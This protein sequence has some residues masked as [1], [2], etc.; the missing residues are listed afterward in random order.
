MAAMATAM[1]AAL[2]V[3][4]C[5]ITPSQIGALADASGVAA[6]IGWMVEYNP[7]STQKAEVSQVVGVISV[8]IGIVGTNSYVDVIFPK[9]QAYVAASTNLPAIDKPIILGGAQAVLGGIDLMFAAYPTWKTDTQNV[10]TYV[11]AFLNGVQT[12]LALPATDPQVMQ[13]AKNHAARMAIWIK[14]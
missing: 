5:K 4:G 11:K 6:T 8:N 2:V 12:A 13:A 7:T 3:V 1:A 10:G 14:R 9:V